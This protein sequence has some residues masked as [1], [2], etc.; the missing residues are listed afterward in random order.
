MAD[1]FIGKNLAKVSVIGFHPKTE[2]NGFNWNKNVGLYDLLDKPESMKTGFFKAIPRLRK[3]LNEEHVDILIACGHLHAPLAGMACLGIDTKMIYWSHSSFH[4]EPSPFKRMSEIL[5]GILS[6]T[7]VTLTKADVLNYKRKTF[8]TKVVQIYNPL[9]QE[10]FSIEK[11]Y[12]PETKKIISVGRLA[13][14]KNFDTHLLEVASLV[15]KQNPDYT[16]HIYGKGHLEDS[17]RK[18]IAKFGLNGKVILEG[19]VNNLYQQYSKHSIMVMTSSYEGFPMSLMEGMAM[20]LPLVSFNVPTGPNEIIQDGINGFLIPPFDCNKMAD[21][22]NE[23]IQSTELR[24]S[25][26]KKNLSILNNFKVE[27]TI[28]KWE[29]L[30]AKITS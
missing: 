21:R 26:S 13:D 15:L 24:L 27:D 8:A 25:F 7:V 11:A 18:N 9:D 16:W 17:I 12:N 28:V 6:Y 22:I 23:L 3:Y 4:G 29:S 2:D 14:P 19:N 5:G 1:Q 20:S 30:I 10:L